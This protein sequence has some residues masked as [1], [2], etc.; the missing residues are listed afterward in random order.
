VSCQLPVDE[1][2]AQNLISKRSFAC[3]EPFE[4]K[5]LRSDGDIALTPNDLAHEPTQLPPFFR[6]S[7]SQWKLWE[8][9]VGAKRWMLTC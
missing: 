7:R 4:Q 3:H 1:V 5:V 2:S 9:P 8:Q 6:T